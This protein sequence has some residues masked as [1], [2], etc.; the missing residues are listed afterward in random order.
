MTASRRAIA[1]VGFFYAAAFYVG[2]ASAS[3]AIVQ[4]HVVTNGSPTVA[5]ALI[6]ANPTTTNVISFVAP[7]DGKAYINYC[8]AAVVN[9]NP[10]ITVDVTNQIITVS[11][12]PPPTNV[13]CP[14]IV[15][16]VDG[17][18]GQFGPLTAG[19]WVFDILQNAYMFNVTEVPLLLSIRALTNSSAL[20]L[21]WPVSGDTFA[22]EYNDNL[23][24]GNWQAVTNPAT[25][26]SNRNTV[27]IYA[28][29]VSRF[30]RLRQL[31][32]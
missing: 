4:W 15:L 7:T 18:E 25:I 32:P 29:S 22:L 19:T 23:A 24:Q 8:L 10:A 3:E 14:E 20:Q 30:F 26:L 11:F 12:S 1:T 6:P 13:A 28:D 21:E 31:H 17:V 9:G 16:P 27:Q 5:F 2:Q